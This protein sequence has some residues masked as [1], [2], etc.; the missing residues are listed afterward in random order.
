MEANAIEKHLQRFL[1]SQVARA[2]S[3]SELHDLGLTD[4]RKAMAPIRE[5]AWTLRDKEQLEVLQK[6]HCLGPQ[7]TIIRHQRTNQIK[8]VTDFFHSKDYIG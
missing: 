1:Q 3:S 5:L 2:L 7:H 6:R 8:K 4:W